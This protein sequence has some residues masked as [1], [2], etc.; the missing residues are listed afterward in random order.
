[1]Q[2]R[3]RPS[4]LEDREAITELMRQSLDLR[5]GGAATEPSFQDWKYWVPHPLYAGS[6]GYVLD[7]NERIVSHGSR[8]PIRMRTRFGDLDTFHLIDWV[9]DPA[10]P[11]AG[12][13][14]LRDCAKG[15]AGVFAI[16]GS[17]ASQKVISAF[18]FKAAHEV[19][20][21]RRPLLLQSVF[22]DADK[23]LKSAA[24][25]VR[26]AVWRFIPRANIKQGWAYQPVQVS[27]IPESF[28]PSA[29]SDEA[30][31]ARDASLLTYVS[32]CPRFKQVQAYVFND[33]SDSAGYFLL[34]QVGREVRLIDF[35][36]ADMDAETAQILGVCSQMAARLDFPQAATIVTVTTE[37][38]VRGGLLASGFREHRRKSLRVLPMTAAMRSIT[39]FRVTMI[40]WDAAC[41]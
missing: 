15:A 6:R 14:L 36:P 19:W 7:A 13:K 39:K 38:A 1:M 4:Q 5:P 21:L 24:R 18:G 40:D 10:T 3:G 23:N 29:S 26:N 16:G 33:A 9:A 22:D 35:G 17:P 2:L 28:F 37:S 34:A 11:G 20:D 8:W 41:L 32:T 12:M 25:A 31:S 30:A 27:E